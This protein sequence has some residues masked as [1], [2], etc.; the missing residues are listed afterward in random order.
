MRPLT[1]LLIVAALSL[2]PQTAAAAEEGIALPGLGGGRLT[3]ADLADRPVI[4]VVWASWSPRCRDVVP[5]INAIAG[6]WSRQARV[7]TV[8]FQEEAGVVRDFLAGKDLRVPVYLDE[9][10]AFSKKHAITTLPGL[11]VFQ[12]GDAAFR[13]KLPANPDPVV[14]RALN[15]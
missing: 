4:L 11:L 2:G 10:G 15:R 13:G 9:T 14:E 7:A 6:K 3:E 8:V 1:V 12:D 5:R